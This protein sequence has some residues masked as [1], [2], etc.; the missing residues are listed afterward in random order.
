MPREKI[1]GLI[2]D[3][4][5]RLAGDDTS[6]QQDL[7]LTQLQSQLDSWEGPQPANGNIRDVTEELLE[8]LE[9]KHPKAARITLEILETLGHLGL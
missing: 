1:E 8:E 5:E 3:L 2:S 9:E 7:L 6:P 4:H